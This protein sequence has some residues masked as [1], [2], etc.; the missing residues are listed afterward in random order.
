[1]CTASRSGQNRSAGQH[2]SL[3]AAPTIKGATLMPT[4]TEAPTQAQ[5]FAAEYAKD[6]AAEMLGTVKKVGKKAG[7]VTKMALGV[8]M[9]HQIG[10]ILGL[11]PL[12]WGTVRE[13]LGSVTIISG[14]V[15]VPIAVD[16]LIM[17][18][19]QVLTTRAVEAAG[20]RRALLTMIFPVL[21]SG[22]VNV[23]APGPWLIRAIFGAIVVFIPLAE[24]LRASIKPD[25]KQMD[26]AEAEIVAQVAPAV[27]EPATGRK[28]PTGCA[29]GKHTRKAPVKA[30]T[31]RKA[32]AVKTTTKTAPTPTGLYT[33]PTGVLIART[34]QEATA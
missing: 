1:M 33:A 10:F 7:L 28:C 9:P 30:K 11:A 12:S 19:V 21:M 24:G 5:V 29:C 13:A 25:F 14:A 6:V 22:T 8:S 2:P 27:V 4:T 20:K 17:I 32:P 34:L 31:T 3:P 16:F 23:I 18:C 15:V 26:Q